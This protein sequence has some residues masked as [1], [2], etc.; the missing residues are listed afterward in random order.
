M[1]L[2]GCRLIERVDELAAL[3][4]FVNGG[5]ADGC[6]ALRGDSGVGKSMLVQALSERAAVPGRRVLRCSG[7][8]AEAAFVLAGLSQLVYPLREFIAQLGADDQRTLAAVLGAVP[9]RVPTVTALTFALLNLLALASEVTPLLVVIDDAHWFDDVSARVIAMAGR[10]LDGAAVR[11]LAACRNEVP[12]A[13]ADGGWPQM[14]LAPLGPEQAERFL[15][16]LAVDL[17]HYA[18][19][20]VLEQ[21]AGNPL[22]LAELSRCAL[23]NTWAPDA[24]L[25]LT[26]RLVAIFGDRLNKLD[27]SVKAQLLRGALDGAATGGVASAP[28]RTR[29]VMQGV[30]AA[31]EHGVL[32]VDRGELVFRHPLVRAA[33]IQT[34]TAGQRRHAYAQLADLYPD[35][36]VRRAAY[37]AHATVDPDP[38]VV[39]T[40]AGAAELTIR[41]G[42]ACQA[43]ELLRRAGELSDRPWRR[44]QLLASAA[45]VALQAAQLDEAERL[46]ADAGLGGGASASALLISSFI[47]LYRY[48]DVTATHRRLVE[49]LQSADDLDGETL[50]RM[51]NVLL[52]V[53]MFAADPALWQITDGL[54][55]S[56]ADRLG[57]LSVI[58][59]DAWA[60]AARRGRTV[61]QR[62][63]EQLDRLA[64]LE[65]W[66]VM[67]VALAGYYVDLIDDF[68]SVLVPLADR[69]IE[70]G[71]ATI[72]LATL[73]L[74][75]AYQLAS[76]Q[77]AE[78]V[79]TSQRGV[80]LC[81]QHHYELFGYQLRG[82]LGVIS[83]CRGDVVRARELAAQVR[84]WAE[85]RR[86]GFLT[87][88]VAQI[89]ILCSFA[90][91]DYESA[92]LQAT[93][94][95]APGEFPPFALH[96][97]RTLFDL[98]E[99]AVH[100]D[101]LNEARR[102]VRAAKRLQFADAPPRLA[103]ATGAAEALCASDERAPALFEK[104][105]GHPAVASFPFEHARIRL[106]YGMRLRRLRRYRNARVV[107]RAAAE[108]FAG[109]G[110]EPWTQRARNELRA[111]GT[112]V[113]HSAAVGPAPLTA[114]ERLV[115]ELAAKGLSNK[116]IAARLCLSPRTVG[117]HLYRLFPKLGVTNRA[118]LHDALDAI[119]AAPDQI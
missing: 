48:G 68:R 69:E 75:T 74:V 11:F 76:G 114:Q 108:I 66:D 73:A 46:L 80:A 61:T 78:A 37:L 8:E 113:R 44:E 30:D 14:V 2:G 101:R 100:T 27:E 10:R 41:R 55:D 13:L 96:A 118:G 86:V 87:G 3:E 6:L 4:S 94:I 58:Y 54:V 12:N 102:H 77:W 40:L 24:P 26:Q 57:E 34:A 65:P 39:D 1:D 117:A 56:L 50:T 5:T 7:V 107:L 97:T 36:V 104:V 111:A 106:A 112:A 115:A 20:G 103:I 82:Y 98:V 16:Q 84:V 71:A 90:E 81:S 29:Y 91:G 22:A 17:P 32:V 19:V 9:D 88:A 105:L 52:A 25:P 70:G 47:S 53:S 38:A 109:L 21:A 33:V 59:R 45:F 119:H 92:Y 42:D 110:A 51:V 18:R 35:D 62:L 43:I 93:A 79:D 49:R 95:T 83:A 67:R 99:A 116:E 15:D 63:K 28:P 64:E 85:P 89:A 60:D 31:I 72:A 23:E